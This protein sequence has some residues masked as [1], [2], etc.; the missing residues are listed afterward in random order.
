MNNKV[1]ILTSIRPDPLNRGGHPSG[2]I[3]EIIKKFKEN[4]VAID[5][6]VKEESTNR[7]HRVF[8]RYGIYLGKINVN[9]RDYKKIIVYP[10]NLVFGVPKIFRKKMVVLGPDSP[11]LR[12]AR[13]YKEMKKI[14]ISI[15]GRWIKGIYY[16]IAKYHE[17]RI[18]KQVGLFLV[19]G[20]TD[21]FWIK[22]NPYI[23]NKPLL[24]EKIKFLRHPILSKVVK[25][26]LKK[27]NI[28]KKRFIFSGDLNY[29][30]NNRFI[31]NIVKELEKYDCLLDKK[32]FNI[33]IV[34]KKNKWIS[35]LF[36]QIEVCNVNYIEWIEDYNEIC[37]IG[38]DVH[39]LPLL[40]G[41]GTKNRTLTALSNGLEIISTPIG[42]ENINIKG[43]TSIYMTKDP[44]K[45]VKYMYELNNK[46][47]EEV[48]IEKLIK[49]RLYFKKEVNIKYNKDFAE[50]ILNEV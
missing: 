4:N 37:V 33:V 42:L 35:D 31:I 30:F 5:I 32:S 23:K 1:L 24:K 2:L 40:V 19:V 22:K 12:D 9:F 3:W 7:I 45:F 18:L 15:L 38:Q 39:C 43:L 28:K 36:E 49:E 8:H 14:S 25:E 48:D 44:K 16:N 20:R 29:K 34:G 26:K 6:F 17:Y 47:F 41:A 11:S 10:E 13:I 21:R 50:F 46:I 27:E